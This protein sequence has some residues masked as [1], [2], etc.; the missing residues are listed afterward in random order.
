LEKPVKKEIT[1]LKTSF[2]SALKKAQTTQDLETV[3]I[4][5][6]GRK[7]KIAA[8]MSQLKKLSLDE[9]KIIGPLLNELKNNCEDAFSHKQ[10]EL[11]KQE[12]AREQATQKFFDVTAY[13]PA[14]YKGSL[15]PMTQLIEHVNN[16]FIS[17]GFEIADGPE[18][19]TEYY[20][21]EALNIPAEHPAREM[22]D[23]FWLDIPGL[24]LR[25]HT[26]PVQIHTM[27][28]RGPPIAIVA[29]GRC[30]RHEATDAT[31][32][33]S[34]MQVEGLLIDKKISMGNLIAMVRE[35]F[36]AIFE[37]ELNLRVRPSFY[38]FVEPG[39]D[40]DIECPFCNHGCSLC[41]QTEW[42]EMCGAGLVHPNV[43]EF[44][45]INTQEYSGLAFGFGLT[46]L[47]MLKYGINDIRLLHSG[48]IEFLQQ[49]Q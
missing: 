40:V 31:H 38:P 20:N 27:E 3:R 17:M 14:G 32:D 15:H 16:V 29:P 2:E 10:Q 6:L 18:V 34:F 44:G 33:F 12:F 26:S 42:I 36:K 11:L 48:N 49:F 35:I 39:I 47:A 19:E 5:F 13:H 1:D 30:Y 46:R 21:F 43:L 25:T 22:F 7:G 24:L 23:T 45:G 41:K 8:L 9:K 28:R 37:K 4:Q